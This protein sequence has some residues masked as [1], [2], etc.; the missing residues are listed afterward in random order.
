MG[1]GDGGLLQ[2][3]PA[4]RLGRD[5][6][7]NLEGA[8]FTFA[9]P[10]YVYDAGVHDFADLAAHADKFD[11]KMYGIEPGSNT[12]MENIIK[13]NAFGLG[14]WKLVE[15]SEQG[16]L[17]QVRRSAEKKDWIVFLGWAPHPMNVDID[18]RYLTGGDDYYGPNYGGATVHTQVRKG[19]LAECPNIAK[20]VDNL[21]FTVDLENVGMGYI[22]DENASPM[23][24]ARQLIAKHPDLLDRWLAGVQTADGAE[25][26]AAVKANLGL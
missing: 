20:L 14:N 24:A 15:L 2:A 17:A 3:L 11:H 1:P 4:G 22:L 7:A 9:V 26:E 16:M 25:G 18:M 6:E 8:K 5:G 19:Y 21:T 23:D 13:A 10:T 12:I